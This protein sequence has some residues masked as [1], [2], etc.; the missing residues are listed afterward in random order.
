MYTIHSNNI[1][2]NNQSSTLK[3]GV[4]YRVDPS[5]ESQF[6]DN[7]FFFEEFID[8]PARSNSNSCPFVIAYMMAF[9]Q[10]SGVAVIVDF[11]RFVDMDKFTSSI[12]QNLVPVTNLVTRTKTPEMINK[13]ESKLFVWFPANIIRPLFGIFSLPIIVGL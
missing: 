11:A 12:P 4:L 2:L 8:P 13:A 5:V 3:T 6:S 7:I 1:I 9:D 10:E